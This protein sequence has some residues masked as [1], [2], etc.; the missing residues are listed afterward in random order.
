MYVVMKAWCGTMLPVVAW[1]LLIE[2]I[3]SMYGN[4]KFSCTGPRKQPG[5]NASS[6]SPPAI[7]QSCLSQAIINEIGHQ[8]QFLYS[9]VPTDAVVCKEVVEALGGVLVG[10]LYGCPG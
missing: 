7:F 9:K 10:T 3:A 8:T 2:Q 5:G 4:H 1:S 6:A